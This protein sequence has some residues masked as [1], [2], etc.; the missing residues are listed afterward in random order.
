MRQDW[1]TSINRFAEAMTLFAVACAGMFPL[2]HLGRPWEFFWLLPYPN[3][4]WLWPQFRSPLVWDVFAV[5]TYATISLVFWYVGLIPD[6]ATMRDQAQADRWRSIAVR[7]ASPS[8]GAVRRGT[9]SDIKS[10]IFCSQGL[11]APLVVSVHSVVGMDF[12]AAQLPGWHSTIFP[13]YFVAGAIFSGFAMVLTLAIP[14]RWAY[15]LQDF[16]TIRHLEN[17]AKLMLVTGLIVAYGYAA[18]AFYGWLS[19]NE[20]DMYMN[21][22]RAGQLPAHILV[23]IFC[24]VH[25]P[26]ISLVSRRSPQRRAAVHYVPNRSGG[27]VDGTIRH[28]HYQPATRLSCRRAGACIIRRSGITRRCSARIGFFSSASSLSSDSCRPFQFPKCAELR[29]QGG[30]MTPPHPD[31]WPDRGIRFRR[32]FVEAAAKPATPDMSASTPS[33]RFRSP[34]G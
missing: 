18:E 33:L 10:P 7:H 21:V 6:L 11:A 23:L 15:G 29:A 27:H 19:G 9:G 17:C 34:T 8:A 31:V 25:H 26:A 12:A 13:P 4:M 3:T 1:R 24:N 28:H 30:G 2:L 20:F 5:S 32:P 14:L 22:N 16:I